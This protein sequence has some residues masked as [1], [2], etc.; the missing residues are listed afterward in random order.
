M[1]LTWNAVDIKWVKRLDLTIKVY[2]IYDNKYDERARWNLSP[3]DIIDSSCFDLKY[4][5][6]WD[7]G[8]EVLHFF[9]SASAIAVIVAGRRTFTRVQRLPYGVIK[10]A[11]VLVK[12]NFCRK[13]AVTNVNFSYMQRAMLYETW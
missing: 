13:I 6:M 10:H 7:W 5:N 4:L 9:F 3:H 11:H 1:D 2:I 8:F 12:R